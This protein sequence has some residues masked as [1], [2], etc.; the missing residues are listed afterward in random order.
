MHSS[1]SC[2]GSCTHSIPIYSSSGGGRL[3]ARRAGKKKIEEDKNE[4]S[5]TGL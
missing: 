4:L 3:V 1:A 5:G 2:P